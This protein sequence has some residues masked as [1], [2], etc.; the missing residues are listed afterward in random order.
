MDYETTL[1]LVTLAE[2]PRV[3]ER[4]RLSR[5]QAVA[6]RSPR[7]ASHIDPARL[8]TLARDYGLP[9]AALLRLQREG[10]QRIRPT[11]QSAAA[12]TPFGLWRAVVSQAGRLIVPPSAGSNAAV[13][14]RRSLG[15]YGGR[16]VAS[17]LPAWRFW[18][19][20]GVGERDAVSATSAHR[21]TRGARGLRTG[22]RRHEI[23]PP[24]RVRSPVGPPAHT[25]H[26]WCSIAAFRG[27]FGGQPPEFD[28]FGFGPGRS[29]LRSA[30]ERW[31]C[32]RCSAPHN[33]ADARSGRRAVTRLIAALGRSGRRPEA[34]SRRR[35]RR[36]SACAPSTAARPCA[37]VWQGDSFL[38][39]PEQPGAASVRRAAI[40]VARAA[41]LSAG[42]AARLGG[43]QPRRR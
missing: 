28:P 21:A 20:R 27:T 2:L 24:H 38:R 11:A 19:S 32:H 3:G 18:P 26:P 34:P 22:C 39:S 15:L 7:P 30:L 29:P 35:D 37:V 5:V 13:H 17:T 36:A 25:A 33:H 23:D 43:R 41:A 9:A 12:L 6:P 40:W 14:P 42:R 10:Y 8:S 1:A 16:A 4:R 31:R